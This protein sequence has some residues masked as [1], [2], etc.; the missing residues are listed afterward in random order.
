MRIHYTLHIFLKCLKLFI[1]NAKV[2]KNS[3][4][5]QDCIQVLNLLTPSEPPGFIFHNKRRLFIKY[6]WST[7][8]PLTDTQTCLNNLTSV[9]PVTVWQWDQKNLDSGLI[10]TAF[11]SLSLSSPVCLSFPSPSVASF[12]CPFSQTHGHGFPPGA[13]P[14]GKQVF[15]GPPGKLLHAARPW[16]LPTRWFSH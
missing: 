9:S 15:P 16:D 12:A 8:C 11:S 13:E 4:K 10:H 5:F 3:M 1:K 7:L 6:R 2:K 14:V